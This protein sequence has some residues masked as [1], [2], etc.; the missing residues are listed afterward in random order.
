[1]DEFSL[2]DPVE[3]AK[4]GLSDLRCASLDAIKK[5]PEEV[6]E[7]WYEGL[8][9]ASSRADRLD[10]QPLLTE[11]Q[12]TLATDAPTLKYEHAF[13]DD[14]IKPPLSPLYETRRWITAYTAGVYFV[15]D[16]GEKLQYIGSGCGGRLGN[17]IFSKRHHEYRIVTDVVLFEREWCHF[18]LAFEALAISRL[19][20]PIN[21]YGKQLWIPARPPYDRMWRQPQAIVSEATREEADQS[22]TDGIG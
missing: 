13:T 2:V 15:Y 9:K 11:F 10:I 7:R 19:K 22:P 6:R 3:I 1:M 21:G 17:R 14:W 16:S 12:G 4:R 18:A 8:M 5:L 20:P